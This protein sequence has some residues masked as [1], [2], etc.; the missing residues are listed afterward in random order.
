[1]TFTEQ[2]QVEACLK[3]ISVSDL[4]IRS[5]LQPSWDWQAPARA[6]LNV[7]LH[8]GWYDTVYFM[9]FKDIFLGEMHCR[10]SAKFGF[11]PR[12]ARLTHFRYTDTGELEEVT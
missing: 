11:D 8:V 1:M 10:Y 12:A 4:L 6:N 9:Q 2:N 5:R 7:L 3:E